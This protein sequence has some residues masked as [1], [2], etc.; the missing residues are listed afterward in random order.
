MFAEY[1][2]E[3]LVSTMGDVTCYNYGILLMEIF[4]RK[5]THVRSIGWRI[6]L[7]EMGVR[8]SLI[9]RRSKLSFCKVQQQAKMEGKSSGEGRVVGS[10]MNRTLN[11]YGI[12]VLRAVPLN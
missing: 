2:S 6:Q 10:T 7:E 4:T 11:V 12:Q 9:Y 1:R 5:K 3:G 8:H